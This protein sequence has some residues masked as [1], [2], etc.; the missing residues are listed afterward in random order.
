[1][2]E[3]FPSSRG[4]RLI[5]VRSTGSLTSPPRTIAPPAGGAMAASHRPYASAIGTIWGR[6]PP[7]APF[8]DAGRHHHRLETSS[9][10]ADIWRRLPPSAP[11]GGIITRINHCAWLCDALYLCVC[12]RLVQG[13]RDWQI[14][15]L[16]DLLVPLS[17]ASIHHP[18]KLAVREQ[19]PCAK[20][21]DI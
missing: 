10:I 6:S 2:R 17:N 14:A 21:R 11:F 4:K 15:L 3:P 16:L 9:T 19:Y 18:A 12:L 20:V 8:G 7:S 5:A 1:M 13:K